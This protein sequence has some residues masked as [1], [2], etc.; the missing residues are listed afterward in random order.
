VRAFRAYLNAFRLAPTIRDRRPPVAAGRQHRHVPRRPRRPRRRQPAAASARRRKRETERPK[1]RRPRDGHRARDDDED[2][3]VDGRRRGRDRARGGARRPNGEDRHADAGERRERTSRRGDDDQATPPP[4]AAIGRCSISTSGA[5]RADDAVVEEEDADADVIEDWTPSCWRSQ[6][7]PQRWRARLPAPRR[8]PAEPEPR[9]RT[10]RSRTPWE[11]LADA[12]DACP[13]RTSSTRGSTC[14]DR[15]GLGEGQKDIDRALNAL[16]RAF[17]LDIKERGIRDE[18]E[19]IGGQYDVGSRRR[20]LPGRASTSSVRSTRPWRC[21]TTPPAARGLGQSRQGEELY[22]GDPAPQVRRRGRAG[23]GRGHL[24]EQQ[25]WEDLAQRPR[26]ADQR[27]DRARCRSG[28]SGGSGCASWRAVR[29]SAGTPYEA[30]DT[31][32]RL[33]VEV[34]DERAQ[35]RR[36][37]DARGERS[38]CWARHE[39]LARLYSRVGLWG[40][41]VDSLKRQAELTT[42]KQRAR[43]CGSQVASVYEKELAVPSAPTEAYEAILASVPTTRRRWPPSIA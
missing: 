38:R 14:E 25:R 35:P 30:I 41:V 12:Y 17:R 3:A 31:L 1:R 40:K 34:A 11:E 29:G 19:R 39:A 5:I 36:R 10:S 2:I 32:E 9:T 43:R 33:L 6:P 27:A 21:T 20:D 16:E 26:E 23:A 8:A 18:L 15:R 24:P 28:P 7:P 37:G 22:D 4:V 13:P 42:D